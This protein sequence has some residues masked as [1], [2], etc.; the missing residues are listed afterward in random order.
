[1]FRRY[2][3]L[4]LVSFAGLTVLL[5]ST[6]GISQQR[7]PPAPDTVQEAQTPRQVQVTRPEQQPTAHDQSD[8]F[9]A[10]NAP[11]SSPVFET[12]ALSGVSPKA[13]QAS[14]SEISATYPPSS[15]L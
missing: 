1:M 13:E 9:S 14:R 5:H 2:A 4:F 8:I 12:R 3:I 11:P 15:S 10:T 6:M 7:T